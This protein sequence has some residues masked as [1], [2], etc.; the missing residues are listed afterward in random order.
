MRFDLPPARRPQSPL[1]RI[2]AGVVALIV[3]GASIVLGTIA[4]A[5][6]L[7]GGIAWLI[8]FRWKLHRLRKQAANRAESTEPGVIEGEY[9]V[10]HE[11]RDTSSSR[12]NT[13]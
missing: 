12:Q 6:L 11:Q 10:V 7:V 3:L 5:V 8:W 1:T 9:V 2:L 13:D 4:L